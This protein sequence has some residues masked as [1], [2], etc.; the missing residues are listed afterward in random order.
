MGIKGLPRVSDHPGGGKWAKTRPAPGIG[1]VRAAIAIELAHIP[2]HPNR[3]S[4]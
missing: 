1:P 4:N 2:V 3:E